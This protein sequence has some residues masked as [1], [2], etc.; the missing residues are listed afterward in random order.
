[1][2][3]L[4][5]DYD[6]A[7]VFAFA[8]G[9]KGGCNSGVPMVCA[10][11]QCADTPFDRSDVGQILHLRTGENDGNTWIVVGQLDDSRWF[12]IEAGCDYTG[13]DC[14]AGGQAWVSDSL[15]NLEQFGYTDNIRSMFGSVY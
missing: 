14:Q 15:Q 7:E 3:N 6:W 1:M 11:S 5:D 13:W 2:R 10:G 12:L 4:L 9:G 8:S